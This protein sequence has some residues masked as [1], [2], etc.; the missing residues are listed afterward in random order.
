MNVGERIIPRYFLVEAITAA[1]FTAAYL[2][3]LV[4]PLMIPTGSLVLS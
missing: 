2:S 3:L 1:F 4:L